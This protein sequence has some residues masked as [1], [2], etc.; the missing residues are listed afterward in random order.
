[1]LTWWIRAETEKMRELTAESANPLWKALADFQTQLRTEMK[2]SPAIQQVLPAVKELAK[3]IA[4][5]L[6]HAP[7]PMPS[8]PPGSDKVEPAQRPR[9]EDLEELI[10][11]FD[12]GE[13]KAT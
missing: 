10:R 1:M 2:G 3:E 5:P 12:A 11:A 9:N 8:D 6:T 4:A 7:V 13:F